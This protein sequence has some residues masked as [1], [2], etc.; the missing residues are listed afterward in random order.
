MF[1]TSWFTSNQYTIQSIAITAFAAL[2]IQVALRA[3]VFSVAGIGFYGLGSY[4]AA[5]LVKVQGWSAPAA[6]VVAV[7]ASAVIGWG[8][9]RVLVRLRDLY[10]GMATVAFTLMIGVVALNWD[11]VTGGALGLYA[12]PIS[13]STGFIL[14]ALLV[15]VV[16]LTFLQRGILGRAFDVSREDEHLAQSMSI[17]TNR[18]RAFAFVLSSVLGALGGSFYS[19]SA[20]AITPTD[21]GFGFIT[22]A[23]GM[24]IVGGFTSW[25]GTVIGTVALVWGPLLLSD[26]GHWWPVVYGAV[27]IAVA[28]YA[29]EG[30]FGLLTTGFRRVYSGVR[31]G[32][33]ARRTAAA[34]ASGSR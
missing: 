12:I 6:I 13:V 27:M 17:D 9:A 7:L 29:P 3:G 5:F 26:L 14:I 25:V 15:V 21:A 19:L 32:R 4:T 20:N 16:L 22:L 24:V 23:L 28:V 18:F 34:H 11:S 8:L 31:Q 10:L 2:S 33:T 1:L 30:L